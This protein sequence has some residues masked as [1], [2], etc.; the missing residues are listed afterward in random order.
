MAWYD[1][2]YRRRGGY[3]N[4]DWSAP[5]GDI[6]GMGYSRGR[7]GSRPWTGGYR[8]GYQGGSGGIRTGSRPVGSRDEWWLGGHRQGRY[9]RDY[10]DAYQRFDQQN[11]PRYSPVGGTYT[12]M[13]GEYRYGRPPAPLRDGQWFSDWTRWF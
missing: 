8:E 11:R 1:E 2:G 4:G 13:G 5:N 9:S 12:A 6:G 10:D 7:S 3:R